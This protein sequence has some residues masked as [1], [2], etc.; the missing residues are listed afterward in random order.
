MIDRLIDKLFDFDYKNDYRRSILMGG[1]F[2]FFACVLVLV[3]REEFIMFAL[4]LA[5]LGAVFAAIGLG[6]HFSKKK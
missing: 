3:D 5:L 2:F 1:W 6:Y 4:G